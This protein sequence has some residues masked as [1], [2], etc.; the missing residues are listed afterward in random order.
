MTTWKKINLSID[1]LGIEII[2]LVLK[3]IIGVSTYED[4]ITY[5]E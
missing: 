4:K 2:K 5:C 3:W 1:Q